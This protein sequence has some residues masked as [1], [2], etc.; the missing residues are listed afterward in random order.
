M[1]SIDYKSQ[2]ESTMMYETGSVRKS[3]IKMKTPQLLMIE[4]RLRNPEFNQ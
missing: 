4:E 3:L 1:A 2:M